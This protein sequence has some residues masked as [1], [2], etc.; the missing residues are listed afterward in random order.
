MQWTHAVLH[1]KAYKNKCNM[2]IYI[3]LIKRGAGFDW[4]LSILLASK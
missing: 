4:N 3:A 1:G 2:C